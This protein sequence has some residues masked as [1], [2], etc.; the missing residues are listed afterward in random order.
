MRVGCI[1]A[2]SWGTTLSVYLARLGHDVLL[3]AHGPEQREAL[4]R[5]RRNVQYLPGVPFPD[6]LQIVDSVIEAANAPIVIVA[7]P[8]QYIRNTLQPLRDADLSAAI[9]VNT[10][11]GIE[12]KTLLRVSELLHEVTGVPMERIVTLSGPS[13]A[14]EVSQGD[15]AA[16]VVAGVSSRVAE[17]VRDVF[18]S[19]TLRVYSST[20]IIGVEL[21]GA[22]KNVIALC[23]GIVDGLKFGDNTKAA[24]IT[25]GLAEMAR[26][27]VALGAQ[28]QTFSGLSGLGDL[29]VTCTSRHSRNRHVGEQI[30]RGRTLEDVTGEMKMVAEGVSTTDSAFQLARR[31]GVEMPIIEQVHQVLFENKDPRLAINDLMSRK[32]KQESW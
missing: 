3:W 19:D 12:L 1:G 14:E 10:S 26:L 20:D 13:H 30:G 2:G 31:T 27:G 9:F 6:R 4:R 22:L 25:R 7:T 28:A 21:G 32:T 8:T 17:Q 18:N 11:K 23:A 15:P 5:D 16:V 29:V 24:L